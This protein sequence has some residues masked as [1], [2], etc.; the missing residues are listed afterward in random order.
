MAYREYGCFVLHTGHCGKP[1]KRHEKCPCK[2]Y[3]P[4]IYK[5]YDW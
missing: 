5:G 4:G 2:S 3:Y 1:S